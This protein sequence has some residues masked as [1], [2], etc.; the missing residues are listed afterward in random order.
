M[1]LVEFENLS[2]PDGIFLEYGKIETQHPNVEY[3]DGNSSPRRKIS[4][5]SWLIIYRQVIN[6]DDNNKNNDDRNTD[7]NPQPEQHWILMSKL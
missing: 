6:N 2:E 3:E 5:K 1:T 4:G 7:P